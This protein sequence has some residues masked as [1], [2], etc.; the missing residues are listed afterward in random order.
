[1]SE[2]SRDP[3]APPRSEVEVSPSMRD[4]VGVD[5][6]LRRVGG[7]C[8][9]YGAL[10]VAASWD[11]SDA[12][13]MVIAVAI[14][15]GM[16]WAFVRGGRRWHFSIAVLMLFGVVVQARLVG[17]RVAQ[18]EAMGRSVGVKV[19]WMLGSSILT[20]AVTMVC[21]LVLWVRARRAMKG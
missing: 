2:E 17:P 5:Q 7:A 21:G 20:C 13:V 10:L 6:V 15:V 9:G 12:V 1:M 18:L 3:Y 4:G 11:G 8:L 14:W 19:W 16:C